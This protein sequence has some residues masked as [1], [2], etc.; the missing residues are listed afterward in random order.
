MPGTVP[1]APNES[2]R[3]GVE[4]GERAISAFRQQDES[5]FAR[6]GE[7][8]Y[9]SMPVAPNSQEAGDRPAALAWQYAVSCD[10][11]SRVSTNLDDKPL[12]GVI[13]RES[14]FLP[15]HVSKDYDMCLMTHCR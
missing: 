10:G 15:E 8:E 4:R 1:K 14:A 5:G 9:Y 7:S 11:M 2:S 13:R 6:D 12:V 3:D